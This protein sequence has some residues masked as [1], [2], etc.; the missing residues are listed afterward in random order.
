MTKELI[1][2]AS[3]VEALS[4]KTAALLDQTINRHYFMELST[5]RREKTLIYY[6][7]MFN[8]RYFNGVLPRVSILCHKKFAAFSRYNTQK[9]VI[10]ISARY[11]GR[12]DANVLNTLLHEMIHVWQFEN[13]GNKIRWHGKEFHA[14]RDALNAC[15]WKIGAFTAKGFKEHE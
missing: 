12:S 7:D 11:P 8:F 9:K 6:Y 10:E 15:G 1:F 13:Y 4:I 2:T 5:A 3:R 14:W